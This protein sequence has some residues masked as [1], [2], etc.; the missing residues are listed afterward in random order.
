MK[1]V[2][3]HGRD[4]V[5]TVIQQHQVC[6]QMVRTFHSHNRSNYRMRHSLFSQ[7]NFRIA[8]QL[9]YNQHCWEQ[10]HCWVEMWLMICHVNAI[11][12]KMTQSL[13]AAPDAFNCLDLTTAILLP[14]SLLLLFTSCQRW[15]QWMHTAPRTQ[16]NSKENGA[17][18]VGMM[19]ASAPK[20][21]FI[22]IVEAGA[23]NWQT[24]C[25]MYICH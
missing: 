25:Q 11:A 2:S 19:D 6:V 16:P 12:M 1:F 5:F 7:E 15:M 8:L 3:Y 9:V 18:M 20:N 10:L 24:L 22:W 4:I 23:A 13:G 21:K 17:E 14:Q